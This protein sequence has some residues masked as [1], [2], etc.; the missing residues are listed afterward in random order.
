MNECRTPQPLRTIPLLVAALMPL[1]TPANGQE[2]AEVPRIEN[3]EC[4]TEALVEANADCYMFFGQEDRDAPGGTIVE[5]PVAV[6]AP[7]TGIQN[8]DPVFFFPG[9][10]G[11]SPMQYAGQMDE[12]G[13][14][15]LVLIE[16]RGFVHA[17]PDLSC[18]GLR[19]SPFFNQLSPVI[20][21]ST[22][23]MERLRIHAESVEECYAKL[24]SEGVNVQKY[25]GY[26]VARDVD[27][28]R[29][30]LGYD[31]I[32]IYGSSAGGSSPRLEDDTYLMAVGSYRPLEDAMRIASH[33]LIVWINE[34]YSLSK[35]DAYELLSV[36]M[37]SNVSQIVDPN[38]TV[39]VK[40]RKEYLPARKP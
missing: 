2:V 13:D 20:V 12:I 32:N 28:I 3:A 33:E 27:E 1:S 21:S 31:K 40:I 4:V 36:A 30:L 18:P 17:K 26:D 16:H 23:T 8:S 19:L 39:L 25:N 10:P 35:L 15:T 24:V 9:G 14:R 5:L 7:E 38:Y 29:T 6:M 22:D 11:G 37:E 34:D